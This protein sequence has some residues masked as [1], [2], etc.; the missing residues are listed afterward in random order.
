MQK[1]AGRNPEN[2]RSS[3]LSA[4][5]PVEAAMRR[6]I[7]ITP[8]AFL[9]VLS[10]PIDLEGSPLATMISS[11]QCYEKF[12]GERDYFDRFL[13]GAMKHSRILPHTVAT[14]LPFFLTG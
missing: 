2:P 1:H 11:R 6:G 13:N 5:L 10:R 7:T 4:G 3:G 12:L 9:A 8:L 14:S